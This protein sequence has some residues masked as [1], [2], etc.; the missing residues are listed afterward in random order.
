MLDPEDAEMLRQ[1]SEALFSMSRAEGVKTSLGGLL[2][3]GPGLG[4]CRAYVWAV[5]NGANPMVAV[6]AAAFPDLDDVTA[7]RCAMSLRD[8][9]SV[10]FAIGYEH[11]AGVVEWAISKRLNIPMRGEA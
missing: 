11:A 7:T 8:A 9:Q 10:R 3:A 4:E 2:F 5:F 1:K 6:I